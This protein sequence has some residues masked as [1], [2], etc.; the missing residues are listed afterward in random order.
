MKYDNNRP[1]MAV[2]LADGI[3]SPLGPTTDSSAKCLSPVGG[4]V[5]LERIIRNCLSCGMSQFVLVLGHRA[6][7]I[8]QFVNK[9]FRGIRITY[10]INDRYRETNSSY[11]LMCA[12]STVG[13]AEFVKL[14][15]DTLFEVKILRQLVDDDRPNVVC[16][17]RNAV[18]GDADIGISASA[19][20]APASPTG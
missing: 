4:S 3:G 2:I 9:T 1:R 8:K 19:S 11:A 6:D 16:I 14:D 20:L 5:I 15:A 18:L 12:A 7:D 17:D 10:V 13:S